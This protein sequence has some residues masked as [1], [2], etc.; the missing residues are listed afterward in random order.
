MGRRHSRPGPRPRRAEGASTR[1]SSARRTR[2]VKAG[3]LPSAGAA[4]DRRRTA[5]SLA[6]RMAGLELNSQP[7]SGGSAP[8]SNGVGRAGPARGGGPSTGA[9]AIRCTRACAGGWRRT[10]AAAVD[11]ALGRLEPLGVERLDG[12]GGPRDEPF[13]VLVRLEVGR[14]RSRRAARGR[15]VR[16]PDADAQAQ[17]VGRAEVLRDR[18]QAVVAGETAAEP[19]LQAPARR[20][21]SRRGRRDRVRLELEELHRGLHRAAR[22]VHVRLGLQQR[23]L[24][25][26]DAHLGELPVE[27]R[28]ARSR[29]AG[30]RARRRRASRRCAGSART[31]GPGCRD[32][33]RAGRYEVPWRR[34]HRRMRLALGGAGLAVFAAPASAVAVGRRPRP[35]ASPSAPSSPSARS[36]PRARSTRR[37]RDGRERRS[38]R[39]RGG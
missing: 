21:R 14:A 20:G 6:A 23:D 34:G 15:R 30:A 38:R 3:G 7:P 16:P 11:R 24:V 13:G 33:R 36:R 35:P 32:R 26:V 28:R 27:L 10:R 1:K 39:R 31:R 2:S 29:R 18:A 22:V 12:V 25:A 9:C 8:P 37:L 19:R 17:E 4:R 5:L